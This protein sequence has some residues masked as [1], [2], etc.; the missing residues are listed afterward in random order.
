M[1]PSRPNN[2]GPCAGNVVDNAF[3][4]SAAKQNM[5]AMGHMVEPMPNS[6][7]SWLYPY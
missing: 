5:Q 3:S 6:W 7:R 4:R 2:D 1:Q